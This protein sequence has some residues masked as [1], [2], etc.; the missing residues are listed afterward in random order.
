MFVD[1][2][3]GGY[4]HVLVQILHVLPLLVQLLLDGEEPVYMSEPCPV[5]SSPKCSAMGRLCSWMCVLSLLL[6]TNVELFVGGL[7]LGERITMCVV[8]TDSAI[9]RNI[10]CRSSLTLLPIQ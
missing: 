9:A 3:A 7:A 4:R 2:V 10:S 1:T 5:I 8:S 6:L